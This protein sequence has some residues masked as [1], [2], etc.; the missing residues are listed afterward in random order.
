MK[1]IILIIVA[2]LALQV[3]VLFA[4]N[5]NSY[6]NPVTKE[7]FSNLLIFLAP[8][9]PLEANFEDEATLMDYAALGPITPTEAT[10]DDMPS[11]RTSLANLAPVIPTVA[12]FEDDI[13][14]TT[15]DLTSLAPVTPAEAD[16]D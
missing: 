3:N 10:F 11:E 7:N 13:D 4:G 5:R 16:F 8:T 14:T 12:N 1:A 9:I 2:V 6:E 15:L